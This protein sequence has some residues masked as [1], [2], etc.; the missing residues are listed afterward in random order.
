MIAETEEIVKNETIEIEEK[1]RILETPTE[2][3][4]VKKGTEMKT[5]QKV[6]QQTLGGETEKDLL[7]SIDAKLDILLAAQQDKTEV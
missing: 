5:E 6:S 1:E 2:E 3:P 4:E 7:K